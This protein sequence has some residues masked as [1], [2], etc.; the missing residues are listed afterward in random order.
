MS[1]SDKLLK[2]VFKENYGPFGREFEIEWK[3]R[4]MHIYEELKDDLIS[5]EI[6][7]STDPDMVRGNDQWNDIWADELMEIA[8]RQREPAQW[9]VDL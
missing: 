5:D 2:S 8:D 7:K 9:K 1:L 6:M 4:I 3:D